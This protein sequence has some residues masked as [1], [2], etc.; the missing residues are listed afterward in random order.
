MA[1]KKRKQAGIVVLSPCERRMRRYRKSYDLVQK[2]WVV[3]TI[4]AF[5]CGWMYGLGVF[6]FG[7]WSFLWYERGC[8]SNV[9]DEYEHVGGGYPEDGVRMLLRSYV[10]L[11][12]V[13]VIASA[14]IWN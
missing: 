3:L 4:A 6:L 12:A 11:A 1:K 8:M 9:V 14:C 10:L 5:F 13:L 7:I 2:F